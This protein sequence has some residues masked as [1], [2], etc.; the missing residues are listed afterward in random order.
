MLFA[1]FQLGSIACSIN[2]V[3]VRQVG[4]LLSESAPELQKERS[5]N[6]FKSATPGS[7]QLAESL[8]VHD[9]N[10]P[11]LLSLLTKGHAS[12]GFVVFDTENLKDRL[13]ESS[14]QP[15]AEQASLSFSKSLA[16]GFRYLD[17]K[18][19]ELKGLQDALS[20]EK[21]QAYLSEH[22][23]QSSLLDREAAFF[24]G[25]AWLMLSN[26]QR[27]NM[28]LV[29]QL[30]LANELIRWVCSKEPGFQNGL[31]YAMEGVYYLA[32]P[33]MFGGKPEYAMEQLEK[34]MKLYPDNLLIPVITIEWYHLPQFDEAGYKKRKKQL[35]PAIAAWKNHVF[36]PGKETKKPT[37]N[38]IFLTRWLPNAWLSSKASNPKYFNL[39]SQ[40]RMFLCAGFYR[41]LSA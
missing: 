36:V 8:L 6:F 4:P 32:K 39:N 16:Y 1:A 9:P 17:A 15:A 10:N 3:A 37:N 19:I 20:K 31:C 27:N 30:G 14:E 38:S 23:D 5:W 22:L 41:L 33:A 29:S 40:K 2:Q 25:T 11:D 12:Y 28:Q 21:A 24:T 18:G 7:L 13:L 34:A 26:Y 35:K